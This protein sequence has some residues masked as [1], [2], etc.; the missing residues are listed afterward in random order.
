MSWLLILSLVTALPPAPPSVQGFISTEDLTVLCAPQ[1]DSPALCIGYLVGAVDQLLAG[2]ARRPATRRTICPPANLSAEAVQTA[3]LLRL[4]RDRA[5]RPQAA[6]DAIR[7]A[8]EAEYA[9]PLGAGVR[10][11]R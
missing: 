9:C 10:P 6:A 1:N 2:Q 11:G 3:L 8:V 5:N 4:G 7:Q